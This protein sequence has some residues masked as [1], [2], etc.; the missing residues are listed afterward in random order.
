MKSAKL[1]IAVRLVRPGVKAETMEW[2]NHFPPHNGRERY[3]E[4]LRQIT[5]VAAPLMST[6]VQ[7]RKGGTDANR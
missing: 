3:L 7:S 5:K 4:L 6:P 1:E 2:S